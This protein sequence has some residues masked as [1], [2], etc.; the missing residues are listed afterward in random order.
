MEGADAWLEPVRII[1]QSSFRLDPE[2]WREF[3]SAKSNMATLS[4]FINGPDYL[5]LFHYLQPEPGLCASPSLPSG[6]HT[7]VLCV[8]KTVQEALPKENSGKFLRMREFIGGEALRTLISLTEEVTWP[9]LSRAESSNRWALGVAKDALKVLERQKSTALVLKAQVEGH[10]FLPPPDALCHQDDLDFL[11]R[12]CSVIQGVGFQEN[13]SSG[14]ELLQEHSPN[15]LHLHENNNFDTSY[16]VNH[17]S[18]LYDNSSHVDQIEQKLSAVHLVHACEETVVEWVE[19]VSDFL[20]QDW[21][22]QPLDQLKPVPSEEFAFWR[23]RLKNLLF[24]QNQLM[25][26]KA[27]Q[28]T[29]ILQAADSV[30][31][32]A[33]QDLQCV[34]QEGVRE[35]EDIMVNLAPVQEKLSE[36]LEMDFYKLRNHMAA[37]MEEVYL[38]WMRSEFYC[39]PSRMLVLLQEIC[40]LF[41]HLSRKFLPGQ[42]VIQVLMSEPGPV[43]G[44][45]RLV[46]H[47]LQTLKLAY[48]QMQTQLELQN[49]ATPSRSWTFPSHLVFIHLD[50]FLRRLLSIQGA[51][52]ITVRFYQLDQTILSGVNGTLLTDVVREAYQDFLVQVRVLSGCNCDPT[53]PEDQLVKMFWFFL[54]RLL[55]QD[56]LPSYL[57]QLVEQVLT[58]L[59]QTELEFYSER[60]EPERFFRFH[61]AAAARLC[62]NRQLRRRA[63]EALR[64][65]R[66][67][68]NLCGGLALSH[69]VLKRF[70]KIVDLL[71]DF[72]TSVRSDWSWELESECGVILNH[73]LIQITHPDHLEVACRYQLEAL[74]Q[75]LRYVT[76]EGHV[77]LRPHTVHLLSCRDD[78]TQKYHCLKQIVV[79][80]NQVV[81]GAMEVE[82]HLIQEHL[83]EL[84]QILCE[85]QRKTWI[86]EG[87]QQQSQQVLIVHFNIREARSNMDAMRRIAHGWAELDL[88]QRSEDSLLESKVKD[89]T[90]RNIKTDGEQ[91]LRLTQVNRSLY[92]AD[93][94]SQAWKRYLDYIDDRVQ[95]GLLQLLIRALHFLTDNMSPQV[96]THLDVMPEN[97]ATCGPALFSVTLQLQET[98]SVFEPTIDG[99]LINV[100]K[101]IIRDIYG[102][103]SLIPRISLSRH[104]NY[105]VLLQQNPEL[106][107]R[108]QEVMCRLL[109]MKEEAEQLRAGLNRYSHLWQSDRT[110]VFQEFLTYGKQLGAEAV[111]A[112]RKP[113]SLKDFQREIQVLLTLSSEVTQLDEVILLNGWLQVDMCPFKTCL[114]SI[115]LDWKHMYTH[116][117]LESATNSLQQVTQPSADDE[118]SLSSSTVS[119]TDTILL[120][121][122]SGVELPEHLAAQLQ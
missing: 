121:E 31:W 19:L 5:H 70:K 107:T 76:R 30:Y 113:P 45:I 91:L 74:L 12:G 26:P 18:D 1:I 122:A 16:P 8:S 109:Q 54:D 21:S 95:D 93:E 62:W 92:K 118:E 116:Q 102:A 14:H 60:E 43:L 99:G 68:Q 80:Y 89:Q 120:L 6:I 53:D 39:W 23:N 24:I 28:M 17:C 57:N 44:E 67:I 77:E 50:T 72:R 114:L 15:S 100:I 52:F 10:T 90:C 96:H 78:I 98:G 94:S 27:Q 88:L 105:Q 49:Q 48:T 111:D 82:L 101:T 108:E 73:S 34:V 47:T 63:E 7:K 13:N 86:S 2:K 104:G 103:A 51:H 119:L 81:G 112:E 97:K 33:L 11:Q 3:V 58:D 106:C 42:K 85:L 56:Q 61:P 46:I 4:R 87:V 66:T 32:T 64:S 69:L 37:V 55:V 75:E 65:F 115:I 29:S 9:L 25:S 36:V 59:D 35:A 71:Q 83:Q 38:L 22:E 110:A 40:N 84:E 20:Q 41:I 79:C 117:L